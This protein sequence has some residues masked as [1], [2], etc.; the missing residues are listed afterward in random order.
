[1]QRISQR[2]KL[3][4]GERRPRPLWRGAWLEDGCATGVLSTVDRFADASGRDGLTGLL[5]R[6]AFLAHVDRRLKAPGGVRL[7]AADLARLRRLNE[8]LGLSGADL[9]LQALASRL[10]A[11]F[12]PGTAPARIGED[13]FA[14]LI[15]DDADNAGAG[16]RLR[17]I[18]ERPL[19]VRGFDIH[20]ALWIAE[21]W[22]EGG[23][24]DAPDA[25]ELMRR[26]SLA[27][28]AAKS[29]GKTPMATAAPR[30]G[31]DGLSR[32]A[33]EADLHSAMERG[34]IVPF[35]QPIANLETGRLA[36]FEALAR[37][38][39]PVRGLVLPDDF[40]PLL[41]DA[42][43]MTALGRHMLK[44]SAAQIAVWR[45]THP[46]AGDLFVAVNLSTGELDDERLVDFVAD[47]VRSN[48][49][50]P[51]VLKV[52]IT[53]SD[54]MRDPERAAVVLEDLAPR[55]RRHLAG[56]F[57]HRLLLPR[58]YL[59]R[60][61]FE[62]LKIDRY[63]VRTMVENEGSAKIV[64][65]V[66]TLGRDLGAGSGRRRG[67]DPRCRPPASRPRLRLRPGLRLL[68]RPR[69]SRSGS[70]P[71]RKL[72]GQSRA[73]QAVRL[74]PHRARIYGGDGAARRRFVLLGHHQARG[75]RP[76]PK[77]A[78]VGFEHDA[79]NLGA[80]QHRAQERQAHRI[81]GPLDLHQQA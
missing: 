26:T 74:A 12:P 78:D 25:Q 54:I 10:A 55:R 50:P 9:V 59:T 1:M 46:D 32:L 19:R 18:L 23:V 53:E 22:A 76:R 33:L 80:V 56:R 62:T 63:F 52:E 45:E 64:R 6:P 67:R 21:C 66:A 60:L 13:E 42:G 8:A 31:G 73:D 79:F 68:P 49:L 7:I 36:G 72:S 77:P 39:H 61:P 41:A 3:R 14:L 48:N 28:D 44:T 11:A 20:P 47:M 57:R 75:H 58:A 15:E 16:V 38:K 65:S 30:I 70:L 4:H 37:W 29:A 71:E 5:D 27:L 2:I 17:E 35:Y 34:E 43:L 51:R 24:A 81:G 69:R 40:L